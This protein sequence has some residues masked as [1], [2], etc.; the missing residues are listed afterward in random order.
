MPPPLKRRR[1]ERIAARIWD[2]ASVV[3]SFFEPPEPVPLP[4]EARRQPAWVGPPD[5]ILGAAVALRAVLARS[6]NVVLAITDATAYPSG[7]EFNLA[8]R[9]R[10]FSNETRRALMRGG[11]FHQHRLPGDEATEG[12]P[13][14]LLRF[15]V[16]LAD[17]RKATTLDTHHWGGGPEPTG[18]VLMQRGGGGGDRRWDLRFW[19]WPLPPPGPV[20]FV[21]EWPLG[22]IAETRIEIDAAPILDAAAQAETLWPNGSISEGAGWTSQ[23]ML[24]HSDDETDDE[25]S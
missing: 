19:L 17:G 15:G 10:S 22:G 25:T 16:Q 13:P 9:V 1:L 18:P 5:N 21:A 14:E 7:F 8:L 11:P 2:N 4:P 6:D 12:I 20:T 24:E 3:M 23:V